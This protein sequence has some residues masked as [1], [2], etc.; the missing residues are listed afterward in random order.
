[1]DRLQV[2]Q[3][4]RREMLAGLAVGGGALT[5]RR[6]LGQGAAP[7]V[8]N[9]HAIDCHNHFASPA[10]IKALQ[11]KE[12]KHMAG[13]TTWFALQN[14]K[15]Y[16]PAKVVEDLDKQGTQTA[17]LSC[18]TPGAWFGNPEETKAMVR[19]MNEYG[20]RMVSDYKG[21]FGLF[22]LLPLPTI[23]DSLKE[24]EYAFDVL[25]ADGVGL[26]SSH[27]LHWHGDVL[28]RPVFDEL[29][30]RS[31][32]VYTHPIDSP[33]CQDIQ[34]GVSPPTIEYNTDTARTIFSLIAGDAATRY[35]NIKF[36][37]SH[38]GGTMPS[39]IERFGIGGP[40]TINDNLA[41]TAEPNSR[42][43]HLRRFF[44][45]TAQ[46]PNVVQMQGLKTIV[47]INQIVFGSDY[48]FGAGMGRHL[49]GLQKAG[50]TEAELKLVHR[51]N[52]L[53]I[54]PRLA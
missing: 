19:E 39:L 23:E 27:D 14:W 42:L 48:P 33:C 21:R 35:S 28:F 45:D 12:G 5:A 51:E 30:R 52:A 20:A 53:R 40:D 15:N 7:I 41:K 32:I 26:M 43:W 34:P 18:T 16:S 11:A 49:I 8:P 54:L 1:M 47:G 9:V 46:S 38:G 31:A 10:Y 22:A 17:M 4:S 29:N 6:A 50:F 24:I 3:L 13:F 36:I 2:N 25:K 44:Y 37:F